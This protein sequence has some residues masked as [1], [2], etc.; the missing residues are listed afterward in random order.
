VDWAIPDTLGR[1]FTGDD[2]E[3]VIAGITNCAERMA[4]AILTSPREY[5]DIRV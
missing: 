3:R 1:V 5:A 4:E 2:A